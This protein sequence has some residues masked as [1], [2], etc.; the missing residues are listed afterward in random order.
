MTNFY[1]FYSANMYGGSLDL[2]PVTYSYNITLRVN[3]TYAPPEANAYLSVYTNGKTIQRY[4]GDMEDSIL[5]MN[6]AW[7]S[8]PLSMLESQ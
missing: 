2:D 5:L 6:L 3:M 4:V 1:P 7:V 8:T